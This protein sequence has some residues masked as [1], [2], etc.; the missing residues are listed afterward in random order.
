MVKKMSIDKSSEKDK[1]TQIIS[2]SLFGN[3]IKKIRSQDRVKLLHATGEKFFS[4][5]FIRYS[6]VGGSSMLLTL[7]VTY[8]LTESQG[9]NYLIPYMISLAIVT[10]SNFLLAMKFIFKVKTNYWSRFSRYIIIYILNV[11]LVRLIESQ[12]KVHYALAIIGV[13]TLLFL[14]KFLIYDNFVF[15]QHAENSKKT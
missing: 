10:I 12:L 13:T 4:F 7:G 5:K 15:H 3:S 1:K 9:W 8:A 11:A 6:L 14:L 2:N